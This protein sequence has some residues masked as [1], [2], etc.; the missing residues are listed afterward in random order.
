M[1]GGR[2]YALQPSA[3]VVSDHPVPDRGASLSVPARHLGTFRREGQT[4]TLHSRQGGSL[5]SFTLRW[6]SAADRDAI[7]RW[8]E[9]HSGPGVPQSP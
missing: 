1:S 3:A 9:E 2:L 5:G 8:L 7:L 4:L 6:V